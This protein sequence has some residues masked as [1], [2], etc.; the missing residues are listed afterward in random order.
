MLYQ[1]SYTPI[2]LCLSAALTRKIFTHLQGGIGR[3]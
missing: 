1:L 3:T 2:V